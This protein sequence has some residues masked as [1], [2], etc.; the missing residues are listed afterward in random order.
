M[1]FDAMA[2]LDLHENPG[3][4]HLVVSRVLGRHIPV[5]PAILVSTGALL[6]AQVASALAGVREAP[7]VVGYCE[8]A[9]GLG[10]DTAR[11]VPRAS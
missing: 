4:A 11:S 3:R 1:G 6:C 2:G 5:R 8:T 10:H 7:V 9:T